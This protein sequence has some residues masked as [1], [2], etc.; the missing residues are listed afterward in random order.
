MENIEQQIQKKS[1]ELSQWDNEIRIPIPKEFMVYRSEKK[2]PDGFYM[3]LR[4][5]NGV[6]Y[7][8]VNEMKDGQW[9]LQYS[10]GSEIIMYTDVPD[11][12]Y[13][14]ITELRELDRQLKEA[15]KE[16]ETNKKENE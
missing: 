3:T 7:Q 11:R 15:N 4:V 9:G 5:K 13:Q 1:R 10:D 12:F 16:S 6:I 14:I 2:L 8:A